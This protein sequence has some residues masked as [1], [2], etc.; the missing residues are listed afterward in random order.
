MNESAEEFR[1]ERERFEKAVKLEEPDRV[2]VTY[3][4]QFFPAKYAGMTYHEYMY[5]Y[6]KARKAIKKVTDDFNLNIPV[7]IPGLEGFLLSL[8]LSDH[9]DI[10]RAA[11]FITGPMHDVLG[12]KYGRFPGR[13]LPENAPF[14]FIGGEYMKVEEY[15]MLIDNPTKFVAEVILP[16]VCRNLE[17]SGSVTVVG[18]LIKLGIEIDKRATALRNIYA[19]Q[20][21]LGWSRRTS[22]PAYAPLDF[23]GD[24]L[25][26]IKNVIL[27]IYRVPEKVKQ[28]CEALTPVIAKIGASG[29][30]VRT[31]YA[32]IPLH[33]NEYLSPKL[34]NEFYW[35][36]LKL[37][38]YELTSADIKPNVFYEGYHDAHLE[39]ILDLPK[40][41]TIA[42]F[43]KTNLHKAKGIIGGHTCIMGGVPASVLIG[44]TPTR[45]E[46]D[47][48]KLLEDLKPGGGF[49]LNA[50]IPDEAKPK[51]IQALIKAAIKYGAY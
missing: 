40:G 13:E 4:F 27:D 9:P 47:T 33:L 32:F 7:S 21:K 10:A 24:F 45:V 28:A 6:E 3:S 8:A 1:L 19:D 48:K 31:Q 44:G 2:P 29:K 25:R 46:K 14:Q 15:D 5:D 51:N 22:S 43:E 30:Q 20:A 17:K 39:T 49:I 38:I 36:S 11:R 12:D 16:R 26:D 50:S 41:K 35:P 18:T 34:Y 42:Q 37:V 23:I